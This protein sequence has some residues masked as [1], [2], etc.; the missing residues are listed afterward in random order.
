VYHYK[1]EPYSCSKN[2]FTDVI[3]WLCPLGWWGVGRFRTVHMHTDLYSIHALS[4]FLELKTCRAKTFSM[5]H[6]FVK[7]EQIILIILC[8][9][10]LYFGYVIYM[11]FFSFIFN[12]Y[13]LKTNKNK[14]CVFNQYIEAV[15]IV[16]RKIINTLC[17]KISFLRA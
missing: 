1:E 10:L 15:T 12:F 5:Y 6:H 7:L 13:H 3:K 4:L 9:V 14:N 17:F 16:W 8:F 2:H 11:L